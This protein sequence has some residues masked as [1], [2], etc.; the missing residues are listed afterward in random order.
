MTL[1]LVFAASA[2][3]ILKKWCEKKPDQFRH[4]T[5]RKT[6]NEIF[7]FTSGK[8]MTCNYCK[9][10]RGDFYSDTAQCKTLIKSIS[11]AT[12][13]VKEDLRTFANIKCI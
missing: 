11:Q 7:S 13:L 12:G 5:L 2:F 10:L 8:Q 1:N 3:S 6:L 4:C 9:M